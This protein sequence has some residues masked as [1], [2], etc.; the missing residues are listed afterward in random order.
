MKFNRLFQQFAG[1]T[2][3]IKAFPL[4]TFFLIILFIVNVMEIHSAVEQYDKWLA[5]LA[6]AIFASSVADLFARR[7]ITYSIAIVFTGAIF[8]NY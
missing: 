3:A 2:D 5:T 4:T 6:V 1:I 8:L 7:V